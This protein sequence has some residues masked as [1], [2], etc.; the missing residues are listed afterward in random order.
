MLDA[1]DTMTTTPLTE[2]IDFWHIHEQ[3][4]CETCPWG[5]GVPPGL[6]DQRDLIGC[7]YGEHD[8]LTEYD[9]ADAE[10]YKAHIRGWVE[11]E[12][13]KPG[14]SRCNAAT[15]EQTVG[16]RG[17]M[18]RRGFRDKPLVLSEYGILQPS[19]C[20]YLGVDVEHGNQLVKDFMTV[21]FDFNLGIGDDPGIDPD[22]GLPSDG[23]RLVQ[24][25]AWYSA[26]SRMS[27]PDCSHLQIGNGSLLVWNRPT[28]PT[29][30]GRHWQAY[31]CRLQPGPPFIWDIEAEKPEG[32]IVS[33]MLIDSHELASECLHVY[34]PTDDPRGAIVHQL[35]VPCNDEYYL[36]TRARGA[37]TDE[38]EFL[39]SFDGGAPVADVI[40]NFLGSWAWGWNK[41][42]GNPVA[43]SAG[44]HSLTISIDEPGVR[45]DRILL[46]DD[47]DVRPSGREP[48]EMPGPVEA[49]GHPGGSPLRQAAGALAPPPW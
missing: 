17:F 9:H 1:M 38:N 32:V 27:S 21:T 37:S 39:V 49:L 2:L 5:A 46:T 48:C 47:P 4:L 18:K 3:V 11:G 10:I 24:R 25:W 30:F 41:F 42:D 19:G 35:E 33:P 6:D 36:W 34:A 7:D 43:L 20:G 15:P 44:S 22:L 29:E 26:N 40:Y 31:T 13:G 45:I 23:N 8:T 28:E 16:M 14:L 12:E